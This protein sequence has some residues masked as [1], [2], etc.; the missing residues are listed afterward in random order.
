VFANLDT[1][2][3]TGVGGIGDDGDGDDNVAVSGGSGRGDFGGGGVRLASRAAVAAVTRGLCMM[4]WRI[5][6]G[7]GR[8]GASMSSELNRRV[9]VV[10][11][12]NTGSARLCL[13]LR[14][15]PPP[16][17]LSPPP[18]L[19]APP[20]SP[21]PPVPV[22]VP[23]PPP[24]PPSVLLGIPP[25]LRRP[26]KAGTLM[27]KF[28]NIDDLP[29]DNGVSAGC[30]GRNGVNGDPIMGEMGDMGVRGEVGTG[31]MDITPL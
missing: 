6:G 10:V 31:E 9:G 8:R 27:R 22:P 23:P 17:S 11:R 19:P 5:E 7:R 28:R 24:P 15:P 26:T 16:L 25:P 12:G 29:V 4:C 1:I 21:A 20:V 2:D 18:P 3:R 30:G 13:R 14:R